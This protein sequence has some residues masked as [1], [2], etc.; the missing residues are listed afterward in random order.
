MKLLKI[1]K[2]LGHYLGEQGGF[3]SIDKITK[4]DILRLVNLTLAEEVELDEYDEKAIKNPAHQI[5]Y[6]NISEKIANLKERRQEFTDASER[7]YL[8][9][10]EKYRDKPPLQGAEDEAAK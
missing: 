1:D 3:T 9:E 8:V 6:K 4:E 5:L 10:Y 2:N 7:L